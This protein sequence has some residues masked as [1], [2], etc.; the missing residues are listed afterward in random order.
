MGASISA[1]DCSC[2]LPSFNFEALSS[3]SS[4]EDA[5]KKARRSL[6]VHGNNFLR[7]AYLGLSSQELSVSLS[8]DY[9][10]V[11]WKTV[12][13]SF[14]TNKPEFGEISL[15]SVKVCKVHGAQGL[16]LISS[17]GKNT[18]LFDA[19]A[20][21]AEIRDRWVVCL[22]ELLADWASDPSSKPKV[23]LSAAGTSNKDAYFKARAAEIDAREKENA[24][25]KKKYASAGMK[26][27]A[28][29]MAQRE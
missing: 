8:E 19:Q 27:T 1:M 24:E 10:L 3:G 13:N 25:R 22:S 9:S 4:N 14:L 26:Y 17:D 7:T 23:Q 11:K 5:E 16:Q 15:D 21:S 18:V 2:V 28:L 29:A 12:S 6:L 20:E